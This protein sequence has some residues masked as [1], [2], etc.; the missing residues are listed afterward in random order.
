MLGGNMQLFLPF[1]DG[2][3]LY[4][5]FTPE[6]NPNVPHEIQAGTGPDI[7]KGAEILCNQAD[8]IPVFIKHA[9]SR[10]QYKGKYTVTGSSQDPAKL[11]GCKPRTDVTRLI[12]LGRVGDGGAPPQETLT[13]DGLE[14]EEGREFFRMHRMRERNR[15]L[16]QAKK[17]QVQRATG[18]L[19][20][21]VCG[22][23]FHQVYGAL[24]RDY[25]QCHHTT[26]ISQYKP[27]QKTRL[28]DLA[29]VCANCHCMLHRGPEMTI[30]RLQRIVRGSR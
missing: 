19:A 3:V 23:D 4:G 25:A 14:A 24:G 5:A 2:K 7:E 11:R 30:Q 16:A 15:D 29:I 21:E 6:L 10:W 22:F 8:P 27:G 17:H 12:Y 9:S 18:R 20:C 13:D 28:K 1:K 26:P